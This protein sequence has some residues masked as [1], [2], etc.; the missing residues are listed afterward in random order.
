MRNCHTVF[1]SS[2]TILHSYQQYTR[3]PISSHPYQHLFSFL[4]CFVLFCFVCN[5][6][7][8]EC[9]VVLI[10]IFLRIND[11]E[12]F[13]KWLHPQDLN[14]WPWDQE[15]GVLPTEPARHPNIEHLFMA[16]C[17]SPLEKCLFR[18][19]ANFSFGLSLIF[20]F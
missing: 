7:P 19:F 3:V 5:S 11:L 14:S 20:E 15:T 2:C 17:V 16:F 6:H 13:L 12:H 4:F 9:E 18:F 1:H 8:S 10:C